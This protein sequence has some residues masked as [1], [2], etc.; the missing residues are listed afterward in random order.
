MSD[1]VIGDTRPRVQFLGDGTQTVFPIPFAVSAEQHLQVRFADNLPASPH[2]LVALGTPDQRVIFEVPPSNGVRITI[3][4]E[5][6]ISSC[7]AFEEGTILRSAAL[8]EGF[9]RLP[10]VVEQIDAQ[11]RDALRKHPSDDDV[12]LTLPPAQAR[13][14]M[15]LSFDEAGR[16]VATN[17]G[18]VS[19]TEG[20][21]S[22]V[23]S[24]DASD[25]M[26]ALL[27][28]ETDAGA[29]SQL[30]LGDLSL[31]DSVTAAHLSIGQAG[32]ARQNLLDNASFSLWQRGAWVTRDTPGNTAD[33][34]F[35]HPGTGSGTVQGI[36]HPIG[37]SPGFTSGL[38]GSV[39]KYCQISP[40]VVS[41]S[42]P[43]FLEQ[44]LE[45][46]RGLAGAT[47]TFS[48][49]L[50]SATPITIVLSLRQ[51]FGS[52]G[53]TTASPDTVFESDAI[54]VGEDWA[55][56]SVTA[57]LDTLEN[58][59]FG[60]QKP[61]YVATRI[62]IAANTS[63]KLHITQ[64]Q[65]ELGSEPTH[66][67]P[68]SYQDDLKACQRFFEKS[69]EPDRP[70]GSAQTNG[71]GGITWT[72]SNLVPLSYQF[73]QPKFRVPTLTYWD[74][75]GN[76]NQF[77]QIKSALRTDISDGLTFQDISKTRFLAMPNS[78]VHS[79]FFNFIAEA[80]L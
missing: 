19:S 57:T 68:H 66:F 22:T 50:R 23:L 34:W 36:Y 31:A 13:A 41:A 49:Y 63:E 3:W 30:G 2:S 46:F 79:A 58:K 11:S 16:P 74:L 9:E 29:R 77:T 75:S 54:S 55:R 76:Q 80:D 21:G 56:V 40:Y 37:S 7:A 60:A 25:F 12:D 26:K 59:E 32:R 18:T 52:G 73:H 5:M 33:R 20:A 47:L 1:P 69:Y 62:S 45:D 48:A 43:Q 14:G 17:G 6:E 44:R 4:R 64:A 28:Q 53:F 70:P 42:E 39:R 72:G 24:I 27:L 10:E 51:N 67:F 78:N 8:N 61:A 35:Y 65:L 71:A 15:V 38:G